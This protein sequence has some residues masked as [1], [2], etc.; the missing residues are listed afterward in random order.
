LIEFMKRAF[1]ARQSMSMANADG[2]IGHTE[3]K[4]GDS[5]IMLSDAREGNPP[6]PTSLYVYV[7]DVDAVYQRAVE[8]GGTVVME[9]QT[10]FYGDRS[11]GV[12]DMCGNNWW[13]AT[14]VEDMSDD[15][16]KRRHKEARAGH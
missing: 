10:H 8:A 12:K 6:M 13:I 15:E 14:H 5:F 9:V 4:I 16:L 2:S 1:G 7:E 11:G 3:M